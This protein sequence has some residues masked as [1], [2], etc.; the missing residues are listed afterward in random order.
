MCI[1][2]YS[3]SKFLSLSL[4]IS[5]TCCEKALRGMGFKRS[6]TE[7]KKNDKLN[8]LSIRQSVCH[9]S[10]KKCSNKF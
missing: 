9:N 10:I 5:L 2:I 3:N 1:T 8:T 6:S 4:C 7:K